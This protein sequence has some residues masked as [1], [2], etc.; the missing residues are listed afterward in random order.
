MQIDAR[1]RDILTN[2]QIAA[3]YLQH[4]DLNYSAFLFCQSSFKRCKPNTKWSYQL[5]VF[6]HNNSIQAVY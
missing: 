1:Q 4:K 5:S 2:I 3:G 6:F